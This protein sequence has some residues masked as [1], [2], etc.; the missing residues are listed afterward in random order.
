V[1]AE[2]IETW[3]PELPG[4][5]PVVVYCMYGFQVS[6]EAVIELRRRGLDARFLAGG[7]T[8][9]HAMGGPTVPLP[10]TLTE[11]GTR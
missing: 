10:R 5:R 4:D 9:W 6:G 2:D 11:G 3:A 1:L 8:T 7:I